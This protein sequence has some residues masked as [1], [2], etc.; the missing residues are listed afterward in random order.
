[1]GYSRNIMKIRLAAA[2]AWSIVL[3]VAATLLPWPSAGATPTDAAATQQSSASGYRTRARPGKDTNPPA[4]KASALSD[5]DLAM[6]IVVRCR[7]RPEL[8]VKRREGTQV[9]TPGVRQGAA[10]Q[11]KAL[12]RNAAAPIGRG[13]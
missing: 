1:M 6:R 7:T 10:E 12:P 8:C 5:R 13:S 4:T 11:K 3:A 2:C 9:E